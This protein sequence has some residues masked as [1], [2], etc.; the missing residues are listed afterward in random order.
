MEITIVVFFRYK[1]KNLENLKPLVFGQSQRSSW[2]NSRHRTMSHVS[3]SGRILLVWAATV[4]QKR[5]QGVVVKFLKIIQ[6]DFGMLLQVHYDIFV[7][8]YDRRK[9]DYIYMYILWQYTY[10]YTQNYTNYWKKLP[11]VL[12]DSI[13]IGIMG[14][15]S[16][17]KMTR[18]SSGLWKTFTD[19][20]ESKRTCSCLATA[21]DMVNIASVQLC[22]AL[23]SHV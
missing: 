16:H 12:W 22:Q 3:A 9:F 23:K 21:E 19:R 11:Y 14:I 2:K 20:K 18:H 7:N 13:N 5:P 10:I 8:S 4:D 15:T 6:V 1:I 17:E